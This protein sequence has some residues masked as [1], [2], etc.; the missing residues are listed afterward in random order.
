MEKGRLLEP[1]SP[2]EQNPRL[3]AGIE[4]ETEGVAPVFARHST[5]AIPTAALQAKTKV[6]GDWV[7]GNLRS[8]MF[9]AR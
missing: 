6:P 4:K 9:V 7:S 8:L 5:P 1:R 2:S 3:R